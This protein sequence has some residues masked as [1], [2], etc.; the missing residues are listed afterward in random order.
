MQKDRIGISLFLISLVSIL[1]FCTYSKLAF[2]S[3]GAI[4]FLGVSSLKE[5]FEF[6][7]QKITNVQRSPIYAVSLLYWG[8]LFFSGL[9]GAQSLWGMI[10]T[11][12]MFSIIFLMFILK[13]NDSKE[14]IHRS[15]SFTQIAFEFFSFLYISWCMGFFIK[16]IYGPFESGNKVFA[17]FIIMVKFTDIFAY[18]VGKRVG[19]TSFFSNIS[20]K[21]TIEGVLGGVILSPVLAAVC[22]M[23]F[24]PYI[25]S[26]KILVLGILISIV[27]VI[28]DLAESYLKRL[29]GVKDSGV[30]LLGIGGILDLLDSLLLT[31]PVFYILWSGIAL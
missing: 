15:E 22:G 25:S 23:I 29:V 11:L 3:F 6:C 27:S 20:P 12:A 2:L 4:A 10:D 21:K 14:I 28:G 8:I 30:M 13:F 18:L 1:L 16:I 31:A 26:I 7:E 5:F 19:K 17:L 24:F 9:K